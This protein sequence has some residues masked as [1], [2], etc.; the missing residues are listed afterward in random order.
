MP[1]PAMHPARNRRTLCASLQLRLQIVDPY[2]PILSHATCWQRKPIKMY[3]FS[4]CSNRTI[5]LSPITPG[6]ES[7]MTRRGG[8][9]PSSSTKQAQLLANFYCILKFGA[10]SAIFPASRI[11]KAKIAAP[12]ENPTAPSDHHTN[13]GHAQRCP[14]SA[15]IAIP[16]HRH[17]ALAPRVEPRKGR[18][19]G[20]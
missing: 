6:D 20:G 3:R 2:R 14:L 16:S 8:K 1:S 11:R 5:I 4:I 18:P 12:S 19:A 15:Q 10:N 9:T 17:R 7:W 13:I